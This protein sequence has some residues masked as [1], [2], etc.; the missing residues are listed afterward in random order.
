MFVWTN[1]LKVYKLVVKLTNVE[2]VYSYV[3]K[4]TNVCKTCDLTAQWTENVSK[5]KIEQ[6]S[7]S[8]TCENF[9]Y[10]IKFT[11]YINM[12]FMWDLFTWIG[13]ISNII[14]GL[15]VNLK[16]YICINMVFVWTNILK[17]Y[18]VGVKLT[19]VRKTR[20]L[21]AQWIKFVSKY[22][23]ELNLFT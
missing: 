1:V 14:W 6:L 12:V 15:W 13:K 19:N 21:T 3:V 2:K 11:L 4:L 8:L 23:I 18:K 5:Y 9:K 10:N 17:A 22:K 20:N 7:V 16:V